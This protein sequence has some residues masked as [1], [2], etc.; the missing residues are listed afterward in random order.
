[1]VNSEEKQSKEVSLTIRSV[2][3]RLAELNLA[4][5]VV[6]DLEDFDFPVDVL[7]DTCG[8]DIQNYKLDHLL[9]DD[10]D[11]PVDI[12][13]DTCNIQN[14]EVYKCNAD[15]LREIF[16][17]HPD[18]DENFRISHPDFKNSFMN[19]LAGL[20]K[21]IKSGEEDMLE[22]KDITNMESMIRDME[23]NGLQLSWLQKMLSDVRE[24]KTLLELIA[25]RRAKAQK[26]EQEAE[27]AEQQ[28]AE[29]KKKRRFA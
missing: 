17:K 24:R 10:F 2:A 9:P 18:V 27:E 12:L 19:S 13:D 1:M 6:L 21:K 3:G 14:Y 25:S 15:A 11:F 28:L 8:C 4:N 23:L 29:L 7:G 22:L 26:A 16:D 5:P 20:F